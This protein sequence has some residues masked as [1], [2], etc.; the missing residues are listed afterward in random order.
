MPNSETLAFS[1]PSKLA[2]QVYHPIQNNEPTKK[3]DDNPI[4]IHFLSI[5]EQQKTK[6]SK[7]N[8]SFWWEKVYD[9]KNVQNLN[10]YILEA[11]ESNNIFHSMQWKQFVF[12]F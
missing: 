1:E 4:R 6:T 12:L 11:K 2:V 9:I 7:L 10:K 3:I 5:Q 8:S